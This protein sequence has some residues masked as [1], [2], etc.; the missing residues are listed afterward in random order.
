MAGNKEQVTEKKNGSRDSGFYFVLISVHGL[1]RGQ[2][3]ELGRDADTGGQTK[4][5]IELARAL[6]ALPEVDRVDL[7][8]RQVTDPKVSDDYAQPE[9]SLGGGARI[10]R[11]P[12]GPR[13]YL[14]KEVLWPYLEGF[15]DQALQHI[16]S[17]GRVPDIIHSHYADA[18][19]V[20]AHLAGILGIPLV[21]TGHSL[22]RDK[23]Q[24]LLSRGMKPENIESQYN[25]STRIE[26]EEYTLDTAALV[27]ASTHQEIEEQYQLYDNYQPKQMVVI[28]PGVEL[29]RFY[30]PKR[31]WTDPP[32]RKEIDRF[33]A[34][35]K[36]PI[37]L[38][39]SRADV[40]K[41][42]RALVTAYGENRRLQELANLVTIVGNRE[43]PSNM[44][45][46]SREVFTEFLQLVDKYDLYGKIAYPKQHQPD[47]VP[48]L[49]RVATRSRG[50]FV[51]PALTEPFGLTIIEAAAC[52]LPVVA[53]QHGGP[54]EIVANCRNG[55]LVDPLD[56]ERMG[57]ALLE[58]L[59][60]RAKWNRWSKSGI[61][62]A[63]KHYSW[64]GHA[65]QY[66]KRVEKLTRARGRKPQRLPRK[67]R[68]PTV[69]RLLICDID[70]TLIG[71]REGLQALLRRI[72][73]SGENIGLGVATGR[74]INSARKV[75]KEWGVPAPDLYITSVG[76]EIYY[77]E[78]VQQD[79]G[80][81][82]ILNYRWQPETIRKAM[83]E[84][85]GL[86][87]QPKAEQRRFK[88]SYYVDTNKA[89]SVR[90]I[91]RYLRRH[92][93]HAH[94]VYSHQAYLDVVPMRAS[95]GSAI[96]YFVDRWGIPLE[97]ILVAGDAG[98]D[99]E[100]LL[101]NTLGVVVANHSPELRRLKNRPRVY[102]ADGSHAWGVMEGME[103]Y[104]FLGRI[105]LHEEE[106]AEV[107]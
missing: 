79:F 103:Y 2:D 85:P 100:M 98:N 16:R 78:Q 60:D 81:Q 26:A 62:G 14:R 18:G 56:T 25:I 17:V 107:S 57:D 95:K 93:I 32:I 92:D 49:Y 76:T 35:P 55:V 41:N 39:L 44:E 6:A 61:T 58:A 11:L 67:S 96:R 69:E 91:V 68:L 82:K 51:N 101:G 73:E 46:E 30:P 4:Y 7:L 1:I 50:V 33:L 70:N 74:H 22:G 84:F 52:G 37:I 75:L 12:C 31:G 38:A 21:H 29:E 63:H 65:R 59:G 45:K 66:L 48:D 105:D 104:D 71:D 86:R 64:P 10:V 90:E 27:I 77:G 43:D 106:E 3:L 89:P 94:V 54:T 13:R 47:D 102:F 34:N 42:V 80:W 19:F 72:H 5:V 8:T 99:E 9:E 53:T 97:H 24:R 83:A 87:L 20:G 88:I 15:T 36:K 28:P 23:K 40:R